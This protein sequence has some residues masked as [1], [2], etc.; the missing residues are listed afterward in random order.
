[1]GIT[2]RVPLL[3]LGRAVLCHLLRADGVD[4]GRPE[5]RRFP[6]PVTASRA[7]SI[8]PPASLKANRQWSVVARG[9][10]SPPLVR[11]QPVVRVG[12]GQREGIA[13]LRGG[14]HRLVLIASSR[15]PSPGY[16]AP[17]PSSGSVSETCLS[18]PRKPRPVWARQKILRQR[19]YLAQVRAV[20]LVDRLR[21]SLNKREHLGE[22]A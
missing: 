14:G 6:A 7:T 18:L 10:R 16:P 22:H 3:H 11:P 1:M 13:V 9:R 21:H 4:F 20:R 15:R 8:P 19:V 17:E 2:R 12:V 5:S